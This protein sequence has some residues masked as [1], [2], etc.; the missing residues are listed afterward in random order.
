MGQFRE[1]KK[2]K[3]DMPSIFPNSFTTFWS[4]LRVEPFIIKAQLNYIP[5]CGWCQKCKKELEEKLE[6]QKKQIEEQKKNVDDYPPSSIW[7]RITSVF[8]SRPVLADTVNKVPNAD[9]T[10]NP[11]CGVM[12]SICVDSSELNIRVEGGKLKVEIGKRVERTDFMIEGLKRSK[13]NSST[14]NKVLEC[15][16]V[17]LCPV[18]CPEFFTID[19]EEF[20]VKKVKLKVLKGRVNMFVS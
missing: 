19:N 12:Q 9:E 11:E 2:I 13:G 6:N 20:E 5:T 14:F 1:A 15:N 7:G 8:S 17:E 16:E 18:Q 4:L 10:V 3:N